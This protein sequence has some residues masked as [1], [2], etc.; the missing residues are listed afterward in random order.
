MTVTPETSEPE[1]ITMMKRLV[2]LALD[3]THMSAERTYMNGERTLAVWIR[4]ALALMIFGLAVDRFS[5]VLQSHGNFNP[6]ELSRWGGGALIVLGVA[7]AVSC[8]SRFLAFSLTYRRM[9]R[10]PAHHGPY[11][12]PFF[13][14]LVALFG[15]ALLVVLDVFAT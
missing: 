4:T 1:Q 9:H 15:I 3:Q 2:E 14:A 6:H 7:M 8:G 10:L 11:L 13:A 5:L 12:G